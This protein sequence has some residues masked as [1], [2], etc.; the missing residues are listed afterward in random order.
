MSG[1]LGSSATV[2]N[3]AI[4]PV[5]LPAAVWGFLGGLGLLVSGDDFVAL[6]ERIAASAGR[7]RE[8][9]GDGAVQQDDF[10]TTDDASR[11]R[12]CGFRAVCGLGPVGK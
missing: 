5:P 9:A 6:R 7:M 3:P 8:L 10:P 11:C 4:G 2:S 12:Y 1:T